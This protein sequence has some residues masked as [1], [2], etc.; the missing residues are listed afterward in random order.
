MSAFAL[1]DLRKPCLACQV[2]AG[3]F[4]GLLT[5]T[6]LRISWGMGWA[7]FG[8]MTDATA[9]TPLPPIPI[10]D[11]KKKKKG[12]AVILGKVLQGHTCYWELCQQ[13][14][15]SQSLVFTRM[16]IVFYSP[17]SNVW[18]N[19]TLAV[20]SLCYR[21]L[22]GGIGSELGTLSP[23]TG[24]WPGKEPTRGEGWLCAGQSGKGQAGSVCMNLHKK[25]NWETGNENGKHKLKER[26][27]IRVAVAFSF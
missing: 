16:K 4:Y 20:V 19:E 27:V 10:F 14:E 7:G 25:A 6:Q 15:T 17:T 24:W 12:K 5:Y 3:G 8:C 18:M 21:D 13:R 11:I 23:T 26:T 2:W 22:Q 9:T 1:P